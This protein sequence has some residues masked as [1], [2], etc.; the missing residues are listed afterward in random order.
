MLSN[1]A[2]AIVDADIKSFIQQYTF[3]IDRVI[4]PMMFVKKH[5]SWLINN[6]FE[7][8]SLDQ[9]KNCYITDGCTG[10]FNDVYK[11]NCFVLV[12]EYPY[13]RDNN[14]AIEVAEFTLL[15]N[16]SRLIIS[17]PFAQTGNPHLNWS[18]ILDYC[19]NNKIKVF[20]DACLSG[21]SCGFLDLSHPA[22][23]H[24]TFSFSK[25]FGTGHVRTGVVYTRDSDP[26][27]SM[28]TN[29][30]LYINHNNA[31]LH[32]MLMNNFSSNYIF[33]KYRKKQIQI[34]KEHNLHYS[35]CVLFGLEN[36]ARQ[37]ITRLLCNN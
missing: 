28:I 27:P 25:A 16:N 12:G 29:R 18:E 14:C 1:K 23:T 22:I 36:N 31:Y 26:S 4:S 11:E 9:F 32:Y 13:H 30:Y 8:V 7:Y 15:P 10:A 6:T 5:R 37:C 21:V 35:D 24:I 3:D 19:Y 33:E 2:I 17:Y 34:C 20:I